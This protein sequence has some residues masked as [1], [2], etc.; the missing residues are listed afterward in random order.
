M[1]FGVKTEKPSFPKLKSTAIAAALACDRKVVDWSHVREGLIQFGIN[2]TDNIDIL[3]IVTNIGRTV[4]GQRFEIDR[5]IGQSFTMIEITS[6][7]ISVD[8]SGKC[9]NSRDQALFEGENSF[10]EIN[11]D[12]LRVGVSY[13]GFGYSIPPLADTVSNIGGLL[14]DHDLLNITGLIEDRDIR[15]A[16]VVSES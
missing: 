9:I 7:V 3:N 8:N 15:I 10:L 16:Q 11:I 14:I 2:T 1:I 4:H 5:F 12:K 13:D 6:P